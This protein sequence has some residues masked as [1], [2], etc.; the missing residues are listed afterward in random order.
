[1]PI[2]SGCL[3]IVSTPQ[4]KS[5]RWWMSVWVRQRVASKIALHMSRFTCCILMMHSHVVYSCCIHMMQIASHLW[6]VSHTHTYDMSHTHTPI[7]C[8][9]HAHLSHR[10]AATQSNAEWVFVCESEWPPILHCTFTI[11][12]LQ[13]VSHKS[14]VSHTSS[15]SKWYG[16]SDMTRINCN[17]WFAPHCNTL[18][19]TATHC[20]TLQHTA[21]HCSTLQHT[22]THC[23]TLQRTATGWSEWSRTCDSLFLIYPTGDRTA[24]LYTNVPATAID[25]LTIFEYTNKHIYINIYTPHLPEP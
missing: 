19:H 6:H 21:T 10:T 13:K 23:N 5:L 3:I 15:K 22:A 17:P 14:D 9:T 16:R 24:R 1:M 11:G 8:L 18:Q 7:I 25:T 4:S 12:I 20:N 2:N